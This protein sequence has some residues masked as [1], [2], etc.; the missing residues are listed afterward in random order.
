MAMAVT[1][2]LISPYSKPDFM[3][4]GQPF[5]YNTL[6][7]NPS[8]LRRTLLIIAGVLFVVL[9]TIGAFVPVL[10]TTIF[11]LLAAAAFAKSSDRLYIW[12]MNHPVIGRLIRNYRL[13]HAVPL[14]TKIISLSFLW[15]TIGS[16]AIFFVDA[17]WVRALL[18]LIAIGVT[19]HITSL[20][21][22]TPE[23][24]E[25]IAR[26]DAEGAGGLYGVQGTV[27]REL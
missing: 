13:Y 16:T 3:Q 27:N 18:G 12:I 8:P 21:T 6:M 26:R 22:L 1:G 10:P 5:R 14:H 24:L 7:I 17:W 4:R 9:G 25:E 11:Y 20:K 23:M 19:W 2:F 15:L